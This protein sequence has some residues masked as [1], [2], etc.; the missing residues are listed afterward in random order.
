MKTQQALDYINAQIRA[1]ELNIESFYNELDKTDLIYSKQFW[2]IKL[3]EAKAVRDEL[4]FIK[5][6]LS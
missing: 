6:M 2:Q 4:L 3:A 1:H 5:K